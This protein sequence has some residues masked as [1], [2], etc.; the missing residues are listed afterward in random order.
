MHSIRKSCQVAL[1]SQ[2]EVCVFANGSRRAFS[3]SSARLRGALPV[4][5]PP[6][7]PELES[8][9]S[10][11]NRKILL[12]YHL[13]KEQ[14]DLVYR[15]DNK[16]KLEAE[17]VEITLG[18]V[19]LS[20][21]HIDRNHLPNRFATFKQIVKESETREDW[22]NVVR[23]L[24]GF[25]NAGI[26]LKTDV[27]EMVVR[28]L[29][30]NG[31][32][33][34]VLKALQRPKASGLSMREWRVLVQVLRGIH[35]KATLSDW[36]K[37][38][39]SKALRWAKQVAELLED[40][41]HHVQQN[42]GEA[43]AQKD[44]R[45]RPAVVAVPTEMAAVLADRYGGNVE[46]AQVLAGRLVAALKQYDYTSTLDTITT[47]SSKSPTDF[48][49]FAGQLQHITALARDLLEPLFVCHALKTARKVLGDAMP[50]KDEAAQWQERT[51]K[52]LKEAIESA[53]R[54]RT[55]EGREASNGF[56]GYLRDAVGR[57]T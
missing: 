21:E 36:D 33:H 15:K 17:P 22:E 11:F 7:K 24:E 48:P 46:E 23:T 26:H 37:D 19:T 8:L 55:R 43:V 38:E 20:L 1:K 54:L 30:L 31:M 2:R 34:L 53:D 25:Q 27:Q 3:G 52:L 49:N 32:Q 44:L 35:D 41:E 51:E 14:Q 47:L 57:C 6:S 16:A 50:M 56:V 40:E 9:L 45:G 18:D 4:F 42:R 12:P 29:N 5:L 39:T 28:H 10:T 13:T